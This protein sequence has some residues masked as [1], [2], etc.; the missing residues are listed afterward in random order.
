MGGREASLAQRAGLHSRHAALWEHKPGKDTQTRPA[1]KGSLRARSGW[2]LV[3]HTCNPG[4]SG[5]RDQEDRSSNPV[6]GNTILKKTQ[7]KKGWQSGSS[8]RVPV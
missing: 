3:A 2:A 1:V 7:H 6:P 4:Y 5:G 8:G